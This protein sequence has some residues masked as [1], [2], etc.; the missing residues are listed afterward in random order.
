ML[1]GHSWADLNG[2]ILQI[3][4]PVADLLKRRR[5]EIEGISYLAI[6]CPADRPRNAAIVSTLR[7]GAGPQT[8][9][10]RYLAGDGS[11]VWVTLH[12]ARIGNNGPNDHLIG[13]FVVDDRGTDPRQLWRQA[14]RMIEFY[15]LREKAFGT[16]L[17]ADRAWLV[18]LYAYL[19]EAEGRTT[20]LSDIRRSIRSSESLIMTWLKAL[21]Q[22]GLVAFSAEKDCSIELTSA[23]ITKLEAM[24][25]DNP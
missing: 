24:L 6:T 25:S 10:K 1:I 3:D 17:F 23:G 2:T 13:T 5:R 7:P 21:S 19:A 8:I 14:R 22:A 12:T 11:E 15:R 4:D 9:R 18:L 20:R 16:Q